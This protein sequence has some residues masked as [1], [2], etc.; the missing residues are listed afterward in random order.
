MNIIARNSSPLPK[1]TDKKNLSSNL[2]NPSRTTPMNHRNA[3]P[4]NGI[5]T[6]A[7]LT[8]RSRQSS[9]RD[10][11]GPPSGR[12]VRISTSAV[13]NSTA[14]RTPATAAARGVVNL[15]TARVA[16]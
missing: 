13:P 7:I 1:N 10:P 11:G 8:R 12:A 4:A 6:D 3:I 15:R 16:G 5:N 9:H 14:N 2:P